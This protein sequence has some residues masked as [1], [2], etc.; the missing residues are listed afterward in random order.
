MSLLYAHLHMWQVSCW[1]SKNEIVFFDKPPKYAIDLHEEFCK[2]LKALCQNF[3]EHTF[4][5]IK[6]S[7]TVSLNNM[8]SITKPGNMTPTDKLCK[9][10]VPYTNSSF[11]NVG[12][13]TCVLSKLLYV[14]PQYIN[15]VYTSNEEPAWKL[16]VTQKVALTHNSVKNNNVTSLTSWKSHDVIP[17][18][19]RFPLLCR[20]RRHHRV[21]YQC[22][23]HVLD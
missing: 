10:F 20:C 8:S 1:I 21:V 11:Y 12:H 5:L 18:A 14:N 7:F 15:S 23:V 9:C 22:H 6:T 19:W 13:M 4:R 2:L 17:K 16:P 3:E